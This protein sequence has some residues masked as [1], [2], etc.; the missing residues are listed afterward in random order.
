MLIE[1]NPAIEILN[2]TIKLKGGDPFALVITGFLV[3]VGLVFIIAYIMDYVKNGCFMEGFVWL[4]SLT[5]FFGLITGLNLYAMQHSVE[6][7]YYEVKF[8][9]PEHFSLAEYEELQEYYDVVSIDGKIYT[10]KEKIDK[11]G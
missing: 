2:T 10:L 3:C 9:D 6:V 7:V 1:N 4:V 11:D 5:L 8:T